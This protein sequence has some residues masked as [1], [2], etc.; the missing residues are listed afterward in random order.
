[1]A[2]I[3]NRR[4]RRTR[5]LVT[6]RLVPGKEGVSM[7]QVASLSEPG[8]PGEECLFGM[9]RSRSEADRTLREIVRDHGLCNKVLGLESGSGACF[10]YQVR[11][12]RGACV[13]EETLALHEAR[14]LQA[15]AGL[16]VR[17]WPFRGAIGVRETSP[18]G[19]RTDMHVFD[20]WRHLGTAD[21]ENRLWEILERRDPLPFDLD[22]YKILARFLDGNRKGAEVLDLS[23]RPAAGEFG[24]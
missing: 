20:R 24:W 8:G 12:C 5:D 15:L 1:L 2:P 22:G 17:S 4:L 10:G 13:G 3:H 23:R 9:F 6:L 14:L 21:G 7:P 19:V 11:K 16:K 18:G